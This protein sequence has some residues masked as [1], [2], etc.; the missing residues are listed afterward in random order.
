MKIQADELEAELTK[1]G[2]AWT[3]PSEQKNFETS[4]II[5]GKLE[6]TQAQIT[7]NLDKTASTKH[8]VKVI[9]EEEIDFL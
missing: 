2:S 4:R 8:I 7:E 9:E 5:D 1:A 6:S 3:S